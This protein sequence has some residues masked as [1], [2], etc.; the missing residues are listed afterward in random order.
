MNGKVMYITQKEINQIMWFPE[1]DLTFYTRFVKIFAS[2]YSLCSAR[3]LLLIHSSCSAI[4]ALNI[5]TPGKCL[6]TSL[7]AFSI[8]NPI[9]FFTGHWILDLMRVYIWLKYFRSYS[10]PS[11]LSV[12]VMC[13]I[14]HY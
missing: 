6:S 5:F 2:T 14:V 11:F 12:L 9:L 4:L 8:I 10:F 7:R 1:R 13:E 3:F